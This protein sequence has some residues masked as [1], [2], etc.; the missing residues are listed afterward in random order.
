MSKTELS[1]V[2]RRNF[3]KLT[4]T[5]A[6]ASPLVINASQ[7]D[8]EVHFDEIYDV[9]VVGSGISGHICATY[10][11]KNKLNVLMIDKMDRIGGNSSIS[12]QDF[13]VMG[14]DLQKRDG[15]KDSIE[16]FTKDLNKVGQ[17][18]NHKNQTLR[19]VKYSNEAYEFAKSCGIKY[20]DK[21]KFLGGHS[22]PR[23]IQTIGGGGQAIQTIHK[24]FLNEGGKFKKETKCDEII[25]N[26]QGEV[27]G[28]KV[29]EKYRFDRKLKNDDRDNTSG[30]KK[31]YRARY[32][33]VFATGGF[34]RDVEY[35]SIA[36]PRLRL[37]YTPSNLSQTAGALKIMAKA[38]GNP[39]Q[40]ALSRFSFGI[41]TEDL[42][43]GIIVD[44][45]SKRFMNEDGDRQVL[46]NKILAHM[47]EIGSSNYPVVIFDSVGW[48]NSHDPRR[49][50][51]FITSGKMH[52]FNTLGELA[53]FF[54]LDEKTL[55][56]TI[57]TYELGLQNNKDEFQKDL[58]KSKKIGVSKAP[59]YAMK[60]APSLSYTPGGIF[61]DSNMK[62]LALADNQP[63]PNLYAVGEAT[64]GVHG[65]SRLTSCSIPD[66]MTS[67]LLCAKN[68]IKEKKI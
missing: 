37:A 59:F 42:I 6:I 23:T 16:L 4:A 12:Q 47:D 2:S 29:R 13:A 58:S 44:D 39:I 55:K 63:I 30:I 50:N 54:K 32:A 31:T 40:T 18:Y 61:I 68:I 60:A 64:G 49:M 25:K 9:I 28:I 1:K 65:A 53:K 34:S 48:S 14:S 5:S 46:S 41:P 52:K 38:G 67:G 24:T 15:V 10:L 66:C 21:L 20:S 33:V 45:R 19:L 56:D 57:Q 35:R 17:G 26:N 27:I 62:V 36:N 3:L 11:A 51:S 43:Y 7:K 8:E 22:V